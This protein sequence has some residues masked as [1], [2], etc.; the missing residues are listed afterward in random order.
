MVDCGS[1]EPGCLASFILAGGKARNI[2]RQR[3]Y[4]V[5]KQ[6]NNESDGKRVFPDH[7]NHHLHVVVGVVGVLI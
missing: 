2:F 5:R 3:C 6:G 7:S 4:W 1:V